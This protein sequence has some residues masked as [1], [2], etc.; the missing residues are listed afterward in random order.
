MSDRSRKRSSKWDLKDGRSLS[1]ENI[2]EHARELD[3]TAWGEDGGYGTRMSPGLS[4]WRRQNYRHSP[5]EKNDRSMRN[6]SRSRSRSPVRGFR[7][8]S[9][10]YDRNR[11]RSVAL[12]RDFGAGR[13]RRGSDCPFVHQNSRNYD[14]SWED[15][16]RKG[17]T[18]KY[19][20]ARDAI[21][22]PS[23]SNSERE[24]ERNRGNNTICKFFAAGNCQSGKY[25]R[26]S[27]SKNS[28]SPRR[29]MDEENNY[30]EDPRLKEPGP[31][32]NA[33]KLADGN[34]RGALDWRVNDRFMDGRRDS[35]YEKENPELNDSTAGSRLAIPPEPRSSDKVL[36]DAAMSPDWNYGIKP[37]THGKDELQYST[38]NNS[39][40]PM[41]LLPMHGPDSTWNG[42]G[43][44]GHSPSLNKERRFDNPGRSQSN[45]NFSGQGFDQN[46]QHLS[47]FALSNL[48]SVGQSN[49]T[50]P[51]DSYRGV[52]SNELKIGMPSVGTLVVD[53]NVPQITGIPSSNNPVIGEQLP[54][55]TNI[56]SS[57]AQLLESG[58]QLPQLYAALSVTHPPPDPANQSNQNL[59]NASIA[60]NEQYGHLSDI[61]EQKG[62]TI[63]GLN[64][65]AGGGQTYG[66]TAGGPNQVLPIES[67]EWKNSVE[68]TVEGSNK[69]DESKEASDDAQKDTENVDGAK[70][71]GHGK[72]SKESKSMRAF[73]FA[74]AEFAK[75][76]LKPSWKDGLVG[77]E[78]YKT[79]VKKVV[80]KVTGSLQGANI[81]QSQEK[82]ENYLSASKP[83]LTK[84]V[85][86]Y[87]D[88]FQK[89]SK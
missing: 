29:K 73:R 47:A 15:R 51:A 36:D 70:K 5:R 52:S 46:Q 63:E 62:D 7:Q 14:N 27:H 11:S 10:N 32:P 56:S 6:R 85:Q 12:C 77:K 39:S 1:P 81:P 69:V 67:R 71:D 24:R 48:H 60:P 86:A 4:D 38:Y 17:G 18:S 64:R 59:S 75:E 20:N 78:A 41:S 26:F 35:R 82:I 66:T 89:S 9:G 53:P 13:C 40:V 58:K 68:E 37:S 61:T 87:V 3:K 43:Q 84:L 55:F 54:Q 83:K 33:G 34:G 65:A 2:R 19:S 28:E 50:M 57:I 44:M 25:C 45:L 31:V 16:Y 79:I 76:L 80:N 23:R 21:E 8:E 42:P 74:L 88:K 22:Y 49:V 30:W 72:K